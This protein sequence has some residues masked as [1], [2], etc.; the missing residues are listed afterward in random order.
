MSCIFVAEISKQLTKCE[1]E[2]S[3]DTED[4]G[5]SSDLVRPEPQ[6][7]VANAENGTHMVIGVPLALLWPDRIGCS[8]L[9][10]DR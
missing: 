3:L 7:A 10:A 2:A 4:R 9:R 5:A 8:R 6:G 1:I